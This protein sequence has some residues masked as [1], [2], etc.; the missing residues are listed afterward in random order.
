MTA[1]APAQKKELRDGAPARR[2]R[3][4]PLVF[5]LSTDSNYNGTQPADRR[6]SDI[7]AGSPLS[8]N[9]PVRQPDRK[10]LRQDNFDYLLNWLDRD[11]ERAGEKYESIRKRLI[12]VFVCRGSRQPEDL[13]DRTFNR[14]ALKAPEVAPDFT[15]EPARYILRVAEYIYLESRPEEKKQAGLEHEFPAPAGPDDAG[16]EAAAHRCLD[17]CLGK[18]PAED[19][20]LVINYYQNEGRAKIDNRRR[21]AE[22]L[23]VGMN[24]LTI[25]ACRIRK[26][27]KHCVM[28]CRQ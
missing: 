21:I 12:K 26:L 17:E 6:N 20:A 19:R 28:N 24:A 2:Q 18:L 14:A 16:V 1:A 10:E 22:R 11:R 4:E 3:D 7:G 13:A 27:L 5:G 15:G 25:R 8:A 23:G 9:P